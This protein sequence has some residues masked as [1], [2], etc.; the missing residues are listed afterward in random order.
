MGR[1]QGLAE[2]GIIIADTLLKTGHGYI[3]HLTLAYKGV[4]AGEICTLIDGVD[5]TGSDLE[6]IVFPAANG[7][8]ELNWAQGK[9]FSTGLFFNKGATLG[10]VFAS[11]T[12]K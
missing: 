6:P 11:L 8:L 7:T 9:E 12:Y 5:A 2:S 4:S 10:S 3:F 1:I